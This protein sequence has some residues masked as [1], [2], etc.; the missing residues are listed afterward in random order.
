MKKL[1]YLLLFPLFSALG[2][3]KMLDTKVPSNIQYDEAVYSDSSSTKSALMGLYS[4]VYSSNTYGTGLLTILNSL[5]ADETNSIS[6][7]TYF[8]NAVSLT[9]TFLGN[10]WSDNYTSIYKANA[11]IEGVQSSTVLFPTTKQQMTGEALFM[12]SYLHFNL[13]N[14]FGNIPLIT[15]TNLTVNAVAPQVSSELV[16]QQIISDLQQAIAYLPA[17]YSVSGG[18]RTRI[19]KFAAIAFLSK[20]YL[21]KKD[22]ANA[23]AQANLII[24]NTLFRMPTDLST[25]FLNSSNEAILQFD[26]RPSG[27]V[28][29]ASSFVPTAGA[30]PTYQ[31][32]EGLLGAFEGGDLRKTAWIGTSVG[33][34]YPAKYKVA[35]IGTGVSEYL[36]LFRLGETYLIRS[37]ARARQNNVDGAKSDL[38]AVR[39]RA[40]LGNT[41]ATDQPSLLQAIERERRVE[42][43]CEF[44]N[45]FFD[46]KRTG[47]ADAVLGPQKVGW[48]SNAVNYP[49]PSSQIGANINLKQNPGY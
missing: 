11:I 7:P 9:D 4:A 32:S 28:G 30:M 10:L 29:L 47:R 24:A 41:V 38:N 2:C 42:L 26:N 48:K 12:R 46:L 23:E 14:T 15:N 35:R 31:V 44:G 13:L 8:D 27:Y 43:F 17:N 36:T 21:Y 22:W 49:I 16:Y 6:Y 34:S 39:N 19:N 18:E 45:R 25:V 33:Y 5:Y 3:S 37:E 20:V 40:G 1:K